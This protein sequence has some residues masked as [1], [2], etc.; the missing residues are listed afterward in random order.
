MTLLIVDGSIR[1]SPLNLLHD[2]KP[3]R[4]KRVWGRALLKVPYLI[5]LLRQIEHNKY[6]YSIP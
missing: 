4:K 5:L 2:L 3:P 6:A 1:G